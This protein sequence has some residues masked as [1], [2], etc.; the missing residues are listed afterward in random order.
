MIQLVLR[1]T[2]HSHTPSSLCFLAS[3][4]GCLATGLGISSRQKLLFLSYR[5]ANAIIDWGAQGRFHTLDSSRATSIFPGKGVSQ[6][7]TKARE[8]VT[9]L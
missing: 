6:P 4:L 9:S 8:A 7:K 2:D 3:G 5:C 1:E